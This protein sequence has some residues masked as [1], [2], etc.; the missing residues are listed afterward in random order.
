MSKRTHEQLVKLAL[1]NPDVKKAYDAM[2]EEFKLLD[3]MLKAR[4]KA[5]KTQD[6]VAKVMKTTTSVIGRLE[7]GGGQYR[8]SPTIAT[9]RKY[10]SA[11][12]CTLEIR[13]VKTKGSR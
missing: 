13:L 10:A 3:E 1:R 2:R 6:D 8:H 7:T 12:N 4:K 5:G 11:V 9:L